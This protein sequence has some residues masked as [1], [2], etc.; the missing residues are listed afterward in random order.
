[1]GLL[2]KRARRYENS[3]FARSYLCSGRNSFLLA[4][5]DAWNLWTTLPDILTYG[6]TAK[7]FSTLLYGSRANRATA[8]TEIEPMRAIKLATLRSRNLRR[9][10]RDRFAGPEFERNHQLQIAEAPFVGSLL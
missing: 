10:E 3:L 8:E 7:N 2:Q 1:M 4:E 6:E 9:I 5:H